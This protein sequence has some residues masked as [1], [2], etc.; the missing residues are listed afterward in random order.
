MAN[1]LTEAQRKEKIFI[2]LEKNPNAETEGGYLYQ[3]AKNA[4]QNHAGN[5]VFSK[6]GF[7]QVGKERN[8]TSDFTSHEDFIQIGMNKQVFGNIP[9]F[10]KYRALKT[11]FQWKFAARWNVYSRNRAALSNNWPFAK[12]I[13]TERYN[14]II[15]SLNKM[16][17]LEMVEIRNGVV[18]G[19]KQQSTLEDKCTRA[20]EKSRGDLDD[21]MKTVEEQLLEMKEEIIE[22]DDTFQK[23]I[24]E[25]RVQQII[26]MKREEH[27]M[28]SKAR[29]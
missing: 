4:N 23:A 13:F 17:E 22:D 10:K 27:V 20:L 8:Q 5:I 12:P 9:F 14:V 24:K 16:K 19:K 15:P 11:F 7:V 28:F 1:L 29:R 2:P 6:Q 21:I 3:E 18:Y 25:A 26:K